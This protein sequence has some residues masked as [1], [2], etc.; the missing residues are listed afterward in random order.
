M[1]V[2]LCQCLGLQ[3][4]FEHVITFNTAKHFII[5]IKTLFKR[6][7]VSVHEAAK[8]WND[9]QLRIATV[10]HFSWYIAAKC[11]CQVMSKYHRVRFFKTQTVKLLLLLWK[12][13]SWF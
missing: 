1:I 5:S 4:A 10:T 9:A 2:G 8:L 13:C 6:F 11:S 7:N 3:T 12:P